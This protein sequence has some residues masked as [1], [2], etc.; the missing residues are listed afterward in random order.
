MA[1]VFDKEKNYAEFGNAFFRGR[2]KGATGEA[3]FKLTADV[4]NA[5]NTVNI[6]GA[7]VT[8]NFYHKYVGVQSTTPLSVIVDVWDEG[9]FLEFLVYG[10]GCTSVI[11]DGVTRPR[12]N[13]KGVNHSCLPHNEVIQLAKGQHTVTLTHPGNSVSADGFIFV[14]YIR[15]TGSDGRPGFEDH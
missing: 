2:L 14:K 10:Q 11:I 4:I 3:R 6:K 9:V 7:A 15:P 5:V 8:Y 13:G 12:Y 1:M